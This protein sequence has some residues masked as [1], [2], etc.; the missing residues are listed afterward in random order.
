MLRLP[1]GSLTVFTFK[2]G[3]LASLAHDLRLSF[4]EFTSDVEGDQV[5][6]T[7][8]LRGLRVDGVVEG[9][10]L[11]AKR[12]EEA[13]RARILA[14]VHGELLDSER[15]PTAVYRARLSADGASPVLEGSLTLR[16]ATL[17]VDVRVERR[18]AVWRGQVEL[19]PSRWGITAYRALFGA[20]KLADKL[21]IEFEQPVE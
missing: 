14:V 17:P 19:L 16:G 20:I 5:V 15:H 3:P 12:P 4:A 9:G 11:D 18:G 1:T 8:P 6:V 10:V 21:R 7:C 13:E 2:D